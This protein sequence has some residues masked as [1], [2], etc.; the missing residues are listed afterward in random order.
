M[1]VSE[2]TRG[3]KFLRPLLSA[4][5]RPGRKA[6]GVLIYYTLECQ[7]LH[8][9]RIWEPGDIESDRILST[10]LEHIGSERINSNMQEVDYKASGEKEF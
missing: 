6:D 10:L 4:F 9:Q 5:K 8:F 7:L 3:K 2:F 1:H